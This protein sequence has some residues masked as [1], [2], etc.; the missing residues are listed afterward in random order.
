MRYWNESLVG[1]AQCCSPNEVHVGG[2]TVDEGC[3]LWCVVPDSYLLQG[4]KQDVDGMTTVDMAAVGG[5]MSSCASEKG[6][7]KGQGYSSKSGFQGAHLKDEASASSRIPP[8]GRTRLLGVGV[9]A[10]LAIG[11]L[12]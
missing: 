5:M 1:M 10:L 4:L 8:V 12:V 7:F 9:W 11:L 6:G 2:E 3:V